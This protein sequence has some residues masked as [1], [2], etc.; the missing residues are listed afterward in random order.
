M[1]DDSAKLSLLD[2]IFLYGSI[3]VACVSV[4]V[5]ILLSIPII[6]MLNLYLHRKFLS[7]QFL[8]S[9]IV[10]SV[11]L[12]LFSL[13]DL[14]MAIPCLVLEIARI[15]GSCLVF[16]SSFSI[17]LISFIEVKRISLTRKPKCLIILSVLCTWVPPL[18]LTI[19]CISLGI[20][21]NEG[22]CEYDHSPDDDTNNFDFFSKVFLI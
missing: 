19:T 3:T 6:K 7:I 13:K 2:K 15:W 17:L 5:N 12:I 9:F 21:F 10:V 22:T 1:A 18:I 11:Y 20:S 14:G 8:I 16:N 4:I